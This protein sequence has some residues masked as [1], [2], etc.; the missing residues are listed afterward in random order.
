[1]D[2]ERV[3]APPANPLRI[4]SAFYL[5]PCP[6]T[7]VQR[8]VAWSVNSV[9]PTQNSHPVRCHCRWSLCG[10]ACCFPFFCSNHAGESFFQNLSR[11]NELGR[12][13]VLDSGEDSGQRPFQTQEQTRERFLLVKW[14]GLPT[15]DATWVD[16]EAR[17]PDFNA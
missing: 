13:D 2:L 5:K 10:S 4:C 11:K 9:T 3:P 14:V 12:S 8:S 17:Y 7:S 6:P 15:E 16:A 1:M